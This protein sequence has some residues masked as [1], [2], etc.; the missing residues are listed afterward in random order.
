MT[1]FLNLKLI[2][3][4]ICTDLTQGFTVEGKL[5]VSVAMKGGVLEKGEFLFPVKRKCTLD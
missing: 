5:R 1:I 4:I 3:R 2:I